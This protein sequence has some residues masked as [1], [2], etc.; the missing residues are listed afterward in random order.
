MP[1]KSG[2]TD[3]ELREIGADNPFYEWPPTSREWS[4]KPGTVFADFSC[5]AEGGPFRFHGFWQ[6][7]DCASIPLRRT[8]ITLLT[9]LPN[10]DGYPFPPQEQTALARRIRAHVKERGHRTDAFGSYI[11]Q[12]FLE[13]FDPE[14]PVLQRRLVAQVAKVARELCRTGNFVPAITLHAIRACKEDPEWLA[15]YTRFVGGDIYQTGNHLKQQINL[16]FGRSVKAAAQ[17]DV[18]KDKRG[19][20]I[21]GKVEGEII[22]SYTLL[23]KKKK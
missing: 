2:Y 11:D 10:F 20:R 14:R 17:A 23:K 7:R 8:R 5:L 4:H 18:Q 19:R 16:E 3:E 22:Q 6:I 12:N 15:A 1:N 13:F 21:R 9:K